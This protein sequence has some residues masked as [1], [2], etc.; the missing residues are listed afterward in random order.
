MTRSV[1]LIGLSLLLAFC[2]AVSVVAQDSNGSLI[3]EVVNT[4]GQPIKNA[5]VTFVPVSGDIVFR[6]ADRR[7]KV[8]LKRPARGN[9]RVVVKVDGYVAQKREIVV[10]ES[11]DKVAF[12]MK[13]RD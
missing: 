12:V 3:V 6:K 2:S 1:R 13:A 10:G 9:Y 7:G 4:A 5:C 11:S 8:R